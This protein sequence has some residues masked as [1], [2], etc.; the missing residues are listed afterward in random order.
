[1]SAAFTA[2]MT[3]VQRDSDGMW[4]LRDEATG[5]RITRYAFRS[6]AAEALTAAGYGVVCQNAIGSTW[7][8][9]HTA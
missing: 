9:G 2:R 1:M 4:Q 8:V 6:D 5:D 3:L 7:E